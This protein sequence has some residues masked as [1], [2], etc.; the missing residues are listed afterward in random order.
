MPNPTQ[1][2]VLPIW[3]QGNNSVRTQPTDGEQ[4]TG[5]T[6]NFRPPSSWH[7]WLF[8]VFSDWIS[9]LNFIASP[10]TQTIKGS[11]AVTLGFPVQQ[12]LG[13]P[14]SAA[15]TVTLPSAASSLGYCPVIKNIGTANNLMVAIQTDDYLEGVVNGSVALAPGN[16]LRFCSDGV[17]GF[18][19]VN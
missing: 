12:Y 19:E 13:D 11:A 5:F 9:W 3:T 17:T 6:A 7:N 4:F 8:G 16:S 15:Y 14:T 1:P 2:G 10:G 18:W